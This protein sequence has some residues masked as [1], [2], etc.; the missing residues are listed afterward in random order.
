MFTQQLL[1]MREA[2]RILGVPYTTLQHW[3]QHGTI[4]S[5]KIGGRRMI[6]VDAIKAIVGE[7]A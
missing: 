1:S 4:D 6:P 3:A 5:R 7:A 2:A